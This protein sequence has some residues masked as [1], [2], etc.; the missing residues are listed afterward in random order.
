MLFP[1]ELERRKLSR[2][3][4]KM[5]LLIWVINKDVNK[6]TGRKNA[7]PLFVDMKSELV[8]KNFTTENSITGGSN[9]K[10]SEAMGII[11]L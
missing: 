9:K 1:I 2:R 8:G 6:I 11:P 3:S 10:Q 5:F 4:I 7:T